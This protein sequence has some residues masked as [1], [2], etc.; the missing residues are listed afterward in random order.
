MENWIDCELVKQ[1]NSEK[2]YWY[3]VLHRVVET[4]KLLAERSLT[5]RGS[6]EFIGSPRNGYFLGIL[7]LISK[8]DPFLA[9]HMQRFGGKGSG[10]TSY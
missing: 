3:N 5:F 1:L 4:I 8:F 7:E 2:I 6:N 9:K 10:N